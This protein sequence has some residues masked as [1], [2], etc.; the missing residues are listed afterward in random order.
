VAWVLA[1]NPAPDVPYAVRGV[2]HIKCDLIGERIAVGGH[3]DTQDR[4]CARWPDD[5][6]KALGTPA[7]AVVVVLGLRQLFDPIVGEQ[8]LAVGSP[9]WELAYRDAV[10]QA[11]AVI[12]TTTSAPVMWFD[13]PCYRWRREQTAGEE[14]DPARIEAVD[15]VLRS[16]L[17]ADGRVTVVDYAARVCDGNQPVGDLRPDGAHPSKALAEDLWRWLQPTVDQA[18]LAAQ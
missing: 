12:R 2:W 13:V 7:D 15:T 4:H 3:T 8:Q 16:E 6:T 1:S 18:V 11:L 14:S 5:W 17:A 10:R 9:E